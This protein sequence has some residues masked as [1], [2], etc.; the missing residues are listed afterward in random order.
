MAQHDQLICGGWTV[1]GVYRA[2]ATITI[3]SSSHVTQGWSSKCFKPTVNY[4]SR[5][6][7]LGLLLL[8]RAM[9][10]VYWMCSRWTCKVY[11]A[12]KCSGGRGC[13]GGLS[14]T[15]LLLSEIARPCSGVGCH[16][17][18]ATKLQC[19]AIQSNAI[20][21]NPRKQHSLAVW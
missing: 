11:L 10:G 9:I 3:G 6:T 17:A 15:S 5:H 2:G 7:L 13:V 12:T 1:G 20:Q 16:T 8:A 21:C 18:F 14:I 4:C 19:N